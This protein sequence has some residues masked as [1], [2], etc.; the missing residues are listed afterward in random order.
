[1]GI[2]QANNTIDLDRLGGFDLSYRAGGHSEVKVCEGERMSSHS[3]AGQRSEA[4]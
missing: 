1:M 3:P 4:S 2:H